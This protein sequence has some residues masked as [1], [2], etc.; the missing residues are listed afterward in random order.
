MTFKMSKCYSGMAA[1]RSNASELVPG[2]RIAHQ[3]SGSRC[4]DIYSAIDGTC[5]RSLN[6]SSN[7]PLPPDIQ[8]IQKAGRHDSRSARD[9]R[10]LRT[11][12]VRVI[13]KRRSH[14]HIASLKQRV[15]GHLESER[16]VRSAKPLLSIGRCQPRKR[17]GRRDPKSASRPAMSLRPSYRR[18]AM[19]DRCSVVAVRTCAYPPFSRCASRSKHANV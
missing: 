7:R 2:E 14:F 1:L 17:S 19:H 12:V 16:R 8:A 11:I 10:A 6:G 5:A 15:D 9:R 4:A 13:L 18:H 3:M